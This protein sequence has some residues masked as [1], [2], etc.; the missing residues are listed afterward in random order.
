MMSLMGIRGLSEPTGSWKM[1]CIRRRSFLSSLPFLSKIGSPSSWADPAVGGWSWIRVLP[2]VD[3]P[4]PD[5]PTRPK[6]SPL[7]TLKLTS[8]TAFTSPMWRRRKPPRIG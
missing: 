8:S 6:T 1:I 3:L 2:R 5:S 7:R 4:Q